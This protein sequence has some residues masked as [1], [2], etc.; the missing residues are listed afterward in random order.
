MHGD[1]GSLWEYKATGKVKANL[2][3]PVPGSG[4]VLSQI[5]HSVPLCFCQSP[6]VTRKP[7]LELWLYMWH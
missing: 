6:G 3:N 4:P 7:S 1:P 5:C 2:G